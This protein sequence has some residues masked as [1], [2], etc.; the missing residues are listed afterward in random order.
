MTIDRYQAIREGWCPPDLTYG[1]IADICREW[2]GAGESIAFTN[3]CFDVIHEGHLELLAAAR[4]KCRRLVIG[5]NHDAWITRH[6]G[7]GRPLQ[8]AAIRRAVAHCMAQADLSIIFEDET[9]ESLLAIV[10]PS[11][12]IIGSDYRGQEILG[13]EHCGEVIMMDRVPGVSTTESIARATDATTVRQHFER[14][15]PSLS[16]DGQAEGT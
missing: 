15:N 4:A 6:K 12:Y 3:G 10:Q 1:E 14:A 7:N 11:V 2:R 13:A 9:A 8:S 5:L 16:A